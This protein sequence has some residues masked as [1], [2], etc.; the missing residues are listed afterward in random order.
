MP[1]IAERRPP[2]EPSSPEQWERYQRIIRSA[3]AHG[4]RYPLERVQMAEVAKD[5]GV[6]IA[7]LYRY[8]PSKTQ[9]FTSVLR[10]QISAL[11]RMVQTRDPEVPTDVAV[12]ELLIDASR[13]LL[14]WPI[15][16]QSMLH[17]NLGSFSSSENDLRVS[18]AFRSMLLKVAGIEHPTELDQRLIRVIEQTWYGML[19]SALN[20]LLTVEEIEADTRLACERLLCDLGSNEHDA[21]RTLYEVPAQ[22]SAAL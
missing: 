10:R 22:G 13:A 11:D 20:G 12:A 17:S 1:R 8:F 18:E 19:I 15:L 3:I 9:L 5:A 7:T 14:R 6:A 4:I 16:A 2:A 21:A